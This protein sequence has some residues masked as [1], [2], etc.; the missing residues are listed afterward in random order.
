MNSFWSRHVADSMESLGQE[1]SQDELAYLALTSKIELPIRDQLAYSLQQRFGNNHDAKI[2]REWKGDFTNEWKEKVERNWKRIDLA[3]TVD[4]QPRLL[5]EAKA[6]YTFDICNKRKSWFLTSINKDQKDLQNLALGPAVEKLI[7]VLAT[8]CD[9]APTEALDGVVKYSSDLRRYDK[10]R[11]TEEELQ[12][13][14]K[15]R[16][17]ELNFFSSGRIPGGQVFDMDVRVYYWLFC[18]Y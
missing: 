11:K 12:Q 15:E 8:D 13:L 4:Q 14:S 2:A 18:V 6:M 16:F 10:F 3:V 9:Q 7:L 5:L 1:F 17:S